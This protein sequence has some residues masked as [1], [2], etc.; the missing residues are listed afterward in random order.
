[1]DYESLLANLQGQFL[2]GWTP[3]PGTS[4]YVGYNDDL[5]HNFFSPFTGQ[6]EPGFH[7]NGRTFFVKVTYLIRRN[8]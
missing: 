5:N 4:F 1:V 8:L 7:R 6:F 3:N 2:L